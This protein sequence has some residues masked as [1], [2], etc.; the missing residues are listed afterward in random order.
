MSFNFYNSWDEK[1]KGLRALARAAAVNHKFR[2][3]IYIIAHDNGFKNLNT[4]TERFLDTLFGDRF[5]YVDDPG[6]EYY[7]E[8][9]Y[10]ID[11]MLGDC[12]DAALM[13]AAILELL[14][15]SYEFKLV[16]VNGKITHIFTQ[17]NIN[18]KLVNF[19]FTLKN[20]RFL[21]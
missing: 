5:I 7:R 8:P 13:T 3:K 21:K 10:F 17:G 18:G 19:D 16:K 12:D 2:D 15:I 20:Q 11:Y 6:V 9:F 1:I 14:S 4:E